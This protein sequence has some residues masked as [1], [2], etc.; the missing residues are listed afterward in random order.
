MDSG[1]A[2]AGVIAYVVH[3]GVDVVSDKKPPGKWRPLYSEEEEK[4]DTTIPALI[5]LLQDTNKR[6]TQ[7]KDSVEY[8][9][10]RYRGLY[11]EHMALK[12]GNL[13]QTCQT[14]Q[15]LTSPGD[16]IM[17]C[18]E[19]SG[20]KSTIQSLKRELKKKDNEISYWQDWY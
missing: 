16:T 19:C 20:G 14:T 9:N 10:R 13:R 15:A 6:E 5:K 8:W 1:V 17:L 3:I 4:V 18:S 7:L 11:Q 2:Y 12:Y